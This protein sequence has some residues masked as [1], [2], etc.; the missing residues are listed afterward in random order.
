MCG[1]KSEGSGTAR[2]H[3]VFGLGRVRLGF[4]RHVDRFVST[5]LALA[6][7]VFIAPKYNSRSG[8]LVPDDIYVVFRPH[9]SQEIMSG[10]V[11]GW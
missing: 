11:C 8:I 4:M 10:V 1:C 5:R 6:V 3:G 9:V 2:A 7:L